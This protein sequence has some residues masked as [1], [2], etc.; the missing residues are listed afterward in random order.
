MG[1][2]SERSDGCRAGRD[3][4]APFSSALSRMSTT[5]ALRLDRRGWHVGAALVSG[6]L[7]Y[8]AMGLEPWWWAAWLAPI[9]VLVAAFRAS[10]REAWAL[11]GVAG[12]IGSASTAGYYAMFIGPVGSAF[13]MLLRALVLALVVARTRA[14]VLGSRHWLTVFV[15]PALMAGFDT[16][17]AVVSRDGT[18]G[19]LAY[20]QM[21][22]VPVIQIAAL[23]G[24]PGIVFV[25]TLFGALVAIVCYCR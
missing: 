2:R 6:G 14:V 10:T 1:P 20:G 5:R 11:A 12:L 16:I 24:A 21:A 8:F 22:A 13:V 4:P 19:S 23:A 17:V 3:V 25:V 15:Y 9:P 7:Q 18:M